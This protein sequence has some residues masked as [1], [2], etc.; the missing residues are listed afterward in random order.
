VVNGLHQKTLIESRYL[1]LDAW[2]NRQHHRLF[3]RGGLY[4]PFSAALFFPLR[5]VFAFRLGDELAL[6]IA[7]FV[8]PVR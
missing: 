7:R 2:R 5:S 3:A 4:S 1:R 6:L 8:A